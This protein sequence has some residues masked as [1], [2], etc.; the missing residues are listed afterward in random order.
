MAC[1]VVCEVGS[2]DKLV[3]VVACIG[4]LSTV[5]THLGS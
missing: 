4:G 3:V 5:M 1:M 2:V